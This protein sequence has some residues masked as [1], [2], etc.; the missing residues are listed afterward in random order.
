MRRRSQRRDQRGFAMLLVFAM[1]AAVVV[2]LYMEAPRLAQQALR[3]KEQLLIDRGEQYQRAIQVFVRATKKY[4]QSLDELEKFQDKRYLRQRYKDPFTGDTEWRLI[5]YENGVFRDS[6][7]YGPKK[8]GEEKSKQTFIGELGFVGRPP[9]D[10]NDPNA[11]NQAAQRR[12]SDRPAIASGQGGEGQPADPN[13]PP[14]DPNQPAGQARAT[15]GLPYGV[16]AAPGQPGAA[17]VIPGAPGVPGMPSFRP[18]N[19]IQTQPQGQQGTNPGANNSGANSVGG[20]IGGSIPAPGG[21][22]NSQTGGSNGFIGGGGVPTTQNPGGIRPGGAQAGGAGG[23]GGIPGGFPGGSPGQ[24]PTA[25][26]DLIR[27]ILTTPRAGGLPGGQGVAQGGLGNGIA[28]VASKREASGIKIY[29]ERTKYDE[30][31]FIYDQNKEKASQAQAAGVNSQGTNQPGGQLQGSQP[32]GPLSGS[33]T[34]SGLGSSSG[35]GSQT[36]TPSSPS[37]GRGGVGGFIGG[38]I[39]APPKQ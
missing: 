36:T 37:T 24:V 30:W 18:A 27:Q 11:Q 14:P 19:P 38:S 28:G 3:A 4:P 15:Q 7:V 16:P 17:P 21:V 6:K 25:A 10:A 9:D 13:A 12:A 39:P 29:N 35:S 33:G 8:D 34:G 32:G 20:F 23:I 26:A 5:H 31:E 1:A 2:M 22:S